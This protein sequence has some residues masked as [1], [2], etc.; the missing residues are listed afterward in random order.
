MEQLSCSNF[1]WWAHSS[2]VSGVLDLI[3][4]LPSA[5]FP[6]QLMSGVPDFNS[7]EQ[8]FIAIG[9]GNWTVWS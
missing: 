9:V 4:E 1:L 8:L 3:A 5:T 2:I 6:G 7:L